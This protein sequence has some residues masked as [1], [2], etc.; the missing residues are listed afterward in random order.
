M[1]DFFLQRAVEVIVT[2]D[3]IAVVDSIPYAPAPGILGILVFF[4]I[5]YHLLLGFFDETCSVLLL[6]LLNSLFLERAGT[7]SALREAVLLQLL[8]QQVVASGY[9][10]VVSPKQLLRVVGVDVEVV[11][12]FYHLFVDWNFVVPHVDPCLLGLLRMVLL[13]PLMV[14]N[15]ADGVSLLRI[16]V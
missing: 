1:L 9:V 11:Q 16:G 5:A 2:P 10:V 3:V 7:F 4:S 14:S 6:L 12:H 15:V 8:H 13:E